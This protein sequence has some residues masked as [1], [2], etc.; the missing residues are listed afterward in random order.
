MDDRERPD[1]EAVEWAEAVSGARVARIAAEAAELGIEADGS[2][3]GVFP[4][5]APLFFAPPPF[6]SAPPASP[7]PLARALGPLW[8]H[9]PR[10]R[11]SEPREA[12]AWANSRPPPESRSQGRSVGF[13]GHP[14]G[15]RPQRVA[16]VTRVSR[17]AP[18]LFVPAHF[19]AKAGHFSSAS[20]H[21]LPFF[22]FS[23]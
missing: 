16:R 22:L 19:H 7:A 3:L 20:A 10:K 9:E 17:L 13:W 14:G 21:F 1:G 15:K 8:P 4:L 2:L 12:G 11:P 23:A 18:P 6:F 5:I